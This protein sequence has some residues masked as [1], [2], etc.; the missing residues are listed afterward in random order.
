MP[1]VEDQWPEELWKAVRE[2]KGG[3]DEG[4]AP[5]TEIGNDNPQPEWDLTS[6]YGDMGSVKSEDSR[7][8]SLRTLP[9]YMGDYEAKSE[10]RAIPS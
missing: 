9:P 3:A 4:P 1:V 8:A 7:P 2:A 10:V 5:L 6:L